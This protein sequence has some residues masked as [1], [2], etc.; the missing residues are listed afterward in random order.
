[1]TAWRNQV[2]ATWPKLHLQADIIEDVARQIGDEVVVAALLDPGGVE[3]DLVVEVVYSRER[4]GL[5]HHLHTVPLEP[6]ETL[7][8]GRCRYR[9]VFTPAISG[10]LVYGVRVYPLNPLLAS[11]FDANT[12]R[13]A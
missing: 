13:W 11:P 3:R 12:I 1:M 10:R 6:I 9:A 8:D 5:D 4:D 7:E 2:D